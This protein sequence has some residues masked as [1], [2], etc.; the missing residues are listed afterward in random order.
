MKLRTW[1]KYA[2]FRYDISKVEDT[3]LDYMKRVTFWHPEYQEYKTVISHIK[4]IQ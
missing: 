4:Y 3:C 2:V 1:W